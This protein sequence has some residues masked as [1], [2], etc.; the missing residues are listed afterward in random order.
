MQMLAIKMSHRLRNKMMPMMRNPKRRSLLHYQ[1]L[2]FVP[3]V[4]NYNYNY[5]NQVNLG[6]EC[7]EHLKDV[8]A[9]EIEKIH[10]TCLMFYV[11]AA[12]KIKSRLPMHVAESFGKIR[13][14]K[15]CLGNGWHSDDLRSKI[16]SR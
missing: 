4:Y 9:S 15:S 14:S 6:P 8:P 2:Y 5:M 12:M 13:F 10:Q 3:Q 1:G 11:T 7:Q 16:F